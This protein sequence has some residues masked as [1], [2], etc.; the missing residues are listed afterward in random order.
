MAD[1]KDAGGEGL[2]AM[3]LLKWAIIILVALFFL[4]MFTG[5]PERYERSKPFL[6][7]PGG[8]GEPI[9]QFG[10]Y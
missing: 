2:E 3:D 8:V 6:K 9:N 10:P 7:A 5:G 1:K 4:W